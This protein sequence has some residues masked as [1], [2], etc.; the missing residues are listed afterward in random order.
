VQDSDRRNKPGQGE[1]LHTWQVAYVRSPGWVEED[2]EL[3]PSVARPRRQR[4]DRSHRG[5]R[6]DEVRKAGIEL[7]LAALDSLRESSGTRPALI[8]VADLELAEELPRLL[9]EPGCTVS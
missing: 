5:I 9:Q 1:E 4:R 2:G 3:L 7:A 8:E 6:S